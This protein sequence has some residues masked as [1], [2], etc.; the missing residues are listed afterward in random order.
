MKNFLGKKYPHSLR[1]ELTPYFSKFKNYLVC[2]EFGMSS[3]FHLSYRKT[4]ERFIDEPLQFEV[5]E[6]LIM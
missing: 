2:V 6:Y 5:M 4:F 3:K 1:R